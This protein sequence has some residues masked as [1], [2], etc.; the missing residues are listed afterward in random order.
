[1]GRRAVMASAALLG[2]LVVIGT[3]GPALA[4]DLVVTTTADVVDGGDG[5][6]SLRE[7]VS[8]AADGDVVVLAAGQTYQLTLCGG[9][10]QEDANADGDLDVVGKSLT[11]RSDSPTGLATIENTCTEERVLHFDDSFGETLTL[12]RLVITGGSIG[13]SGAGV[14][15]IDGGDLAV[16][17]SV[18]TD[19][20]SLSNNDGGGIRGPVDLLR[21]TVSGNS[22]DAAGGGIMEADGTIVNSTI[23]GNTAGEVGGGVTFG[24]VEIVASTIVGNSAPIAANVG[25]SGNGSTLQVT[26]SVLG[27][28]QGGGTSCFFSGGPTVTSGGHNVTSDGSCGLSGTGDAVVAGALGLGALGANGGLTPTM[29]PAATSPLAGVVPASDCVAEDQRGVA[30]PVGPACEVG[31]VEIEEATI[32]PPPSTPTPPA[33][34]PTPVPA[35]PTFTG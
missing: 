23:T 35:Q 32:Q 8:A 14:M 25:G 3:P 19:N 10:A 16:T 24:D 18:I 17:D 11:I 31:A 13:A 28:P 20:H 7:A 22:A 1:M 26:S 34:T 12:E 4:A 2:G 9:G 30:R 6:T 33:P 15:N 21:S 29:L 27:G 5:L